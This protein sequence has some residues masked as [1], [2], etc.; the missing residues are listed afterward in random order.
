[1][2]TRHA[3]TL[4]TVLAMRRRRILPIAGERTGET[5]AA[6]RSGPNRRL[7]FLAALSL[8][9]WDAPSSKECAFAYEGARVPTRDYRP[10]IPL[11]VE[12]W[13]PKTGQTSEVSVPAFTGDGADQFWKPLLDGVR[14]IVKRRG[15]SE[16]IIMLGLGGDNR[17][18]QKTG[19][20]LRQ[21]APYARWDILSHYSGDPGPKDGKLIVVGGLEI[22]VR[23]W[24][25]TGFRA[26]SAKEWEQHVEK[27]MEFLDL[28]TARG[29]YNEKSPPSVYRMLSLHYGYLSRVGL[30]FWS[31]AR[32]GSWFGGI[33]A[34]VAPGPEGAIPTAR[35]QMFREG[36]Q[37]LEV[38]MGI[39]RACLKLPEAQRVPYRALLDEFRG[40]HGVGT[41]YLGPGGQ[42][43]VVL[44]YV[45]RV[46]QA[47]AELSGVKTDTRW[48]A[49]PLKQE[50]R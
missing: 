17:P 2:K 21:W 27:P 4:W 10:K 33:N 25:C 3:V 9:I 34:I 30:D 23:E 37:D 12:V 36:V 40:L 15:W 46:H 45:A 24:P 22:G 48:D 29:A 47:A 6:R 11:Q 20:V 31:G 1:M 49:P 35:F 7:A 42:G 26:S 8:L 18:S 13:D 14:A 32:V 16:R 43:D 44:G 19:D 39:V 5:P 38:R 41:A 50:Q 28:S